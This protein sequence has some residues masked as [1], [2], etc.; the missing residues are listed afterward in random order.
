MDAYTLYKSYEN[1]NYIHE[2]GL[3]KVLNYISGN[4]VSWLPNRSFCQNEY[5]AVLHL[6]IVC[7]W[8]R[9]HGLPLST[10]KLFKR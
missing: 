2:T 6:Y 7:K 5:N 4:V 10:S 1:G 3:C 9:E 8:K